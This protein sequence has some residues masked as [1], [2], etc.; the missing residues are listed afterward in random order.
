MSVA[1][2]PE[3]GMLATGHADGVVGL[4]DVESRERIGELSAGS[5]VNGVG[6]SPDGNFIAVGRADG[7]VL[8]WDV[9]SHQLV[10][11]I[12]ASGALASEVVFSPDGRT[13]ATG[14]QGN[15]TR[16]IV[17]WSLPEWATDEASLI[18]ALCD[19]ARRS[20][21]LVEWRQYVRERAYRSTC[22]EWPAERQA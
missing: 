8:L 14:A 16:G 3:G 1:F 2:S 18:G 13:L 9:A 5:A 12:Q 22:P 4:W 6:F 17:V 20:L 19:K 21:N 11:E 15:H 10:G 7:V